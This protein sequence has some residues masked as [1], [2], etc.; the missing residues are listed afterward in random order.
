MFGISVA[1]KNALSLMRNY[2][3]AKVNKIKWLEFVNAILEFMEI[4]SGISYNQ[5]AK[6][7][8][9]LYVLPPPPPPNDSLK[10]CIGFVIFFKINFVISISWVFSYPNGYILQ[11]RYI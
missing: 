9:K 4:L 11:D 6:L 8:K 2:L 7:I 5:Q 3:L 10:T 1:C